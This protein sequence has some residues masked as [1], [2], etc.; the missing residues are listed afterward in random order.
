MA[1]QLTRR[2]LIASSVGAVIASKVAAFRTADAA[3]DRSKIPGFGQ[4]TPT[5]NGF[6]GVALHVVAADDFTPVEGVTVALTF[7]GSSWAENSASMARTDESGA[8]VFGLTADRPGPY[9]VGLR[10]PKGSRFSFTDFDSPETMLTIL[11]DGRYM[12]QVFRI[13]FRETKWKEMR[14]QVRT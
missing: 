14:E 9:L 3:D 2:V 11:P 8:V 6:D 13:A 10:P 7:I 4:A 5:S 12:P 1:I